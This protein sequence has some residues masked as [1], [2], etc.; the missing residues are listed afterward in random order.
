MLR[1]LFCSSLSGGF[2]P[3]SIFAGHLPGQV[4]YLWVLVSFHEPLDFQNFHIQSG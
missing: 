3:S 4:V 1:L 2:G